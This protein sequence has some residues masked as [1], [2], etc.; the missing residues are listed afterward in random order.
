MTR[1]SGARAFKPRLH[2][3]FL[4]VAAEQHALLIAVD[5]VQAADDNSAAFLAALGQAGARARGS[6]LVAT[7]TSGDEVVA[8]VPLRALRKRAAG[9]SS[10]A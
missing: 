6:V 8:E 9:S 5:N 3:W 7:Q 10:R 2:D 4:A 1:P